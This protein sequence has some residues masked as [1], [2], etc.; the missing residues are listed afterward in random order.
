MQT[1]AAI[2]MPADVDTTDIDLDALMNRAD[3]KKAC[4]AAI[5]RERSTDQAAT[6][7]WTIN[8]WPIPT[9]AGS[10][11]NYLHCVAGNG[12]TKGSVFSA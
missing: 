3:V 9:P 11:F 1:F 4:S 12:S 7:G 6:K 10:S 8:A 2:P 5:M